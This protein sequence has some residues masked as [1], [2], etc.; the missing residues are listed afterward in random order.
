MDLPKDVIERIQLDFRSRADLAL[1]MLNEAV[2]SQYIGDPR[3]LRC[4]VYLA[5]GNTVTL[6]KMIEAAVADY[7]RV[8]FAAEYEG[9][10]TRKPRHV[11]DFSKP[12]G[13]KR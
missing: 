10:D 5:R 3:L 6:S 1:K 11:R 9:H 13:K 4:I 12:F 2:A 7:R 8:L